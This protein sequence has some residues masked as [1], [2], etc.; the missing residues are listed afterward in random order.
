MVMPKSTDVM[1][2]TLFSPTDL[3]APLSAAALAV[4]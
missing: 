3:A 1:A 2:A 4:Q